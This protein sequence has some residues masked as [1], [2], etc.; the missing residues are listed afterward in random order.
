MVT[1]VVSVEILTLKFTVVVFGSSFV[2][3]LLLL[4]LL[5]GTRPPE[6]LSAFKISVGQT[7]PA[8]PR[9]PKMLH[10]AAAAQAL[11]S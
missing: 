10:F 6:D 5:I 1:G 8:I 7:L 4:L 11:G 3:S 2:S 9:I